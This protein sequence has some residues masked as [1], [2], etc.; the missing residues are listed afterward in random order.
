VRSYRRRQRIRCRGKRVVPGELAHRLERSGD[1]HQITL[2][3]LAGEL[4]FLGAAGRDP[5]D[6]QRERELQ[7]QIAVVV[8]DYFVED[9]AE[10][11]ARC[12]LELY[13][14]LW[15]QPH[16]LGDGVAL[17]DDSRM[18]LLSPRRSTIR[19]AV[20][21]GTNGSGFS[22][23]IISPRQTRL[24]V[25]L[26][27]RGLALTLMVRDACTMRSLRRIRPS[28]A[29]HRCTILNGL[30]FTLAPWPNKVRS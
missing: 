9:G 17:V 23:F 18:K 11:A 4:T 13:R 22:A 10:H 12:A 26:G 27:S 6:C 1:C 16:H 20:I 3:H 15:L 2:L 28:S 8:L 19:Q 30:N 7:R 25:S 14:A 29:A 5:L 24:R 21:T